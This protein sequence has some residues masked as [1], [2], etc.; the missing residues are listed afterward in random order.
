MG[1]LSQVSKSNA[2][3]PELYAATRIKALSLPRLSALNEKYLFKFLESFQVM[4]IL[5]FLIVTM[6]INFSKTS[7]I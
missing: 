6:T 4:H 7:Q 3:K 5:D 1:G 2:S